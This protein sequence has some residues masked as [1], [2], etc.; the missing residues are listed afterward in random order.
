[1]SVLLFP[2][3]DLRQPAILTAWAAVSVCE[4]IRDATG[5]EAT[6]K[7][8][9][10]VLIAGRKVCGILCEGGAHHV[11]AGIGINVNQSSDDFIRLGL[12]EATSLAI[13][14]K[15]AWDVPDLTNRLIRC[16]DDAYREMSEGKI[17]RLESEW[18]SRIGLLNRQ[19]IVE[20]MDGVEIAVRL[21]AVKFS[22]VEIET[23]DNLRL[24]LPPE[25]I[26]HLRAAT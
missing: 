15:K 22:G 14:A 24:V 8:P 20:R 23:A 16:L 1:M 11:V 21:L 17:D 10:D 19:V 18:S 7:W 25:A 12:L 13:A 9:N 3:A 6:I 4:T 26:R 2:P 5:L